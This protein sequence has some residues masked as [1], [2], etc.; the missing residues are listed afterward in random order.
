[1]AIDLKYVQSWL[2]NTAEHAHCPALKAFVE[3]L[4]PGVIATNKPYVQVEYYVQD[5]TFC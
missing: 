3:S 4:T 1:L 5:T 2:Q